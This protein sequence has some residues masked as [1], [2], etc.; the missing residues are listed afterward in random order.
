METLRKKLNPLL[1]PIAQLVERRTFNPC[2]AGSSPAGGTCK[3]YN[4]TTL[5]F[6]VAAV[7]GLSMHTQCMVNLLA[8]VGYV[9]NDLLP[10]GRSTQ[11]K[12]THAIRSDSYCVRI[13]LLTD[14]TSSGRAVIEVKQA[15]RGHLQ[16]NGEVNLRHTLLVLFFG[17]FL[18][19]RKWEVVVSVKQERHALHA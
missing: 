18:V 6:Y 13:F 7:I 4:Q 3:K 1:A 17:D 16:R 14:W 12:N 15:T 19:W 10:F 8:G 9:M 11:K 5:S 2:V